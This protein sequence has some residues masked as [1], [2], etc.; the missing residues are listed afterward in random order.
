MK[1]VSLKIKFSNEKPQKSGVLTVLYNGSDGL[2][3]FGREIDELTGG[4]LTRAAK[5]AGF[6]GKKKEVMS[7]A[8]P[9][10]CTMSRI[11]VFGTGDCAELTA[12]DAELLGGAIFAQINQKGDK[13]AAVSTS[14]A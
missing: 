11:V 4:Q 1:T 12:R 8:A 13:T 2:S 10:N 6:K 14:L 3:P 7:V 9:A 5:A